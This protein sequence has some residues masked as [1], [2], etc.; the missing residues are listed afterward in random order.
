MR[1][2][3]VVGGRDEALREPDPS[4]KLRG[5]L[6]ERPTLAESLCPDEV[7]AEVAVAETKPALAAPLP[8]GLERAPRLDGAAPA[9]LAV[10]QARER[11]QQA[12]EVGRDVNA[13]EL[14]VVADVADHGQLVRAE[15]SGEPAREAGAS[16]SARQQDDLHAGTAR[17][18]LVLGPTRR[19]MRSRS[20]SSSTSNASSG[21]ETRANGAC[22]RKRSALPGP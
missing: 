3:A 17:S 14:E 2:K 21:I 5:D 12:V 6:G 1:P 11:V 16:A 19:T 22:A 8:S 18:A 7:E 13:E 9:S 10:D 20:S 15:H 4:R